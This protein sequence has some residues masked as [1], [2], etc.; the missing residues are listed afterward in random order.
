MF[1]ADDE[2]PEKMDDTYLEETKEIDYFGG[3]QSMPINDSQL[4][5]QRNV[6]DKLNPT[7]EFDNESFVAAFNKWILVNKI[8]IVYESH[9]IVLNTESSLELEVVCMK[10]GNEV[11]FNN[12]SFT[13]TR[14]VEIKIKGTSYNGF[15][16]LSTLIPQFTNEGVALQVKLKPKSFITIKES[17][18]PDSINEKIRS[19]RAQ[20]TSQEQQITNLNKKVS[21]F[22]S[23]L[24]DLEK[25]NLKIISQKIEDIINSYK[26]TI[27]DMKNPKE[28]IKNGIAT[29]GLPKDLSVI[30]KKPQTNTTTTTTTTET[31]ETTKKKNGKE[32]K[33]GMKGKKESNKSSDGKGKKKKKK[34]KRKSA[35]NKD[36]RRKKKKKK[37]ASLSKDLLQK[38]S[39]AVIY[40]ISSLFKQ[41]DS[42]NGDDDKWCKISDEILGKYKDNNLEV[43]SIFSN[44]DDYVKREVISYVGSNGDIAESISQAEIIKTLEKKDGRLELV[45]DI[46]K[47]PIK[48]LCKLIYD[49]AK[50]SIEAFHSEE[51]EKL[52]S[53]EIQ[54]L[55]K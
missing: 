32:E 11:K 2:F 50:I 22:Y 46:N 52:E 3:F 42:Y 43:P 36:K 23:R 4:Q 1:E 10:I 31:I 55:F 37:C 9:H 51:K 48:R 28:I 20:L 41:S 27:T 44:F 24:D 18:L 30:Q 12:T 39:N 33:I 17:P 47:K 13:D 54:S 53:L 35:D 40:S 7:E 49:N 34:R 38:L 25:N 8:N 16:E 29:N 6:F 5:L 26:Q 15:T 19:L 21:S 45:F 14:I